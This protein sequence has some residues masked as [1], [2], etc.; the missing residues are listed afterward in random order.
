MFTASVQLY[1]I[2]L[3]IWRTRA[4]AVSQPWNA[5]VD[6]HTKAQPVKWREGRG[7]VHFNVYGAVTYLNYSGYFHSSWNI[8]LLSREARAVTC[9]R[10]MIV[11]HPGR[12]KNRADDPRQ[13]KE[14][15]AGRG[16]RQEQQ[17][18]EQE[19]GKR[20]PREEEKPR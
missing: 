13:G 14:E 7:P 1:V 10:T 15:H 2:N 11:Y 19:P 3:N 12:G 6:S 16:S 20:N 5:E 8:I 9:T 17:P 4:P 18:G